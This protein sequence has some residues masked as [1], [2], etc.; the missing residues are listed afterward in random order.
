MP[1]LSVKG[2]QLH[3]ALEGTDGAPV[4]ALSNSLSTDLRMWQPQMAALTSRYRVLRYDVRGH[5]RSAV[6]PAPYSAEM[7]ADDLGGLIEGLGL[8]PVHVVGLSLGG[9]TAQ[10]LAARRPELVRSLALVATTC[11]P[12]F[13]TQAVWAARAQEVRDTGDFSLVEGPMLERW[14]SRRFRR[15][16]PD[17]VA[18]VREMIR[19]TTIEGYV[20]ACLAIGGLDVCGKLAAFG[21]KVRIWAGE[22]DPGTTVE[23]AELIAAGIPGAQMVVVEHARHLLNWDAEAAFTPSLMGWL[24]KVSK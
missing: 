23:D 7:L 18:L 6:A 8:G 1:H 19:G 21:R 5:G 22:E 17:D 11:R 4:V 13:G 15:A 12:P 9:M 16:R 24:E 3:Y 2:V 14:L 20:G 10:M